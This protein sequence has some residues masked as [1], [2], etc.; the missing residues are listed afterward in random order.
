MYEGLSA[1]QIVGQILISMLFLGTGLV[2]ATTKVRQHVDR[3]VAMNIPFAPVVLWTG[4]VMQF[5]G[6]TMVLLD[7]RT[8]IGAVILIVFTVLASAIFHRFWTVEDPLRRHFHIS[9]LFSNC[10]VIGGLLLLVR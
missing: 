8:G 10:A 6:G 9:F 2:N 5:V 4:F 3:M 7:Y 1:L